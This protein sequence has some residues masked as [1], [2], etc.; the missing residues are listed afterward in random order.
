MKKIFYFVIIS[1]ILV[2]AG[3]S[4]KDNS[5]KGIDAVKIYK[6]TNPSDK[7]FKYTTKELF[8]VGEYE[9]DI[10][11]TNVV[12][13][14]ISMVKTD[15]KGNLYILDRRKSVVKKFDT[16]GEYILSM[17]K[18][19]NGPGEMVRPSDMVISEDTIYVS[20]MRA[21]KVLKFDSDGNYIS[22]ILMPRDTGTPRS[23]TKFNNDK[24]VGMLSNVSRNSGARVMTIQL[25][26]FDRKFNVLHSLYSES[27]DFDWETYNPMDHIIEF[28]T[29][30]EKVYVVETSNSKYSIKVY[31]SDGKHIETIK[32]NFARIR[33]SDEEIAYMKEITERRFRRANIDTDKMTFKNSIK[34]LYIDKNGYLLVESA[35]KTEKSD[36]FQFVVDIFKSGVFLNTVNFN[37][38]NDFYRAEDEFSKVFVDDK[39]LIYDDTNMIV[40]VY[41]Y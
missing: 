28:T 3:C 24:F 19:G 8:S 22:D 35:R 26:I 33:Y 13:N 37:K 12:L 4:K 5:S 1:L 6:N 21:R 31:D 41:S 30:N 23:F 7:N 17:G 27:F 10:A 18:R 32:K 2:F 15:S 25:S 16:K 34:K 14:D 20:D 36:Q 39:L 9:E 11:D 40:K 38:D 29:D